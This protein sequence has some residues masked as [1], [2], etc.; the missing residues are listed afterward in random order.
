MCVFA[1]ALLAQSWILPLGFQS[2]DFNLLSRPGTLFKGMAGEGDQGD[3]E[4]MLRFPVWA[5][6]TVV[7]QIAGR[8]LSPVGFHAIGWVLHGFTA[9]LLAA[10]VTR[11]GG[12]ERARFAGLVAGLG[13]G[14][15]TGASQAMS[16]ISAQADVFVTC[17]GVAALYAFL[18]A[19]EGRGGLRIVAS[20]ALLTA[21]FS[22]GPALV[23]I[24]LLV[25][26]L[27]VT[28]VK[29]G[30]RGTTRRA[31]W[32]W[33][34]T[35]VAIVTCARWLYLNQLVPSYPGRSTPSWAW[36]P[37]AWLQL[38]QAFVPLNRDPLVGDTLPSEWAPL[39][40]GSFAPRLNQILALVFAGP[41]LLAW[42]MSQTGG[43]NRGIVS[44]GVLLL[45]VT[46]ASFP[47]GSLAPPPHTPEHPATN[48][49][50]RTVYLG[51]AILWIALGGGAA[52]ALARRKWGWVV[53]AWAFVPLLV[54][55]PHVVAT[56]RLASEARAQERSAVLA[57]VRQ[58]R[59]DFRR[60]PDKSLAWVAVL[61]PPTTF[62]GVAQHG[63]I[64][65]S[66]FRPPFMER[67][68]MIAE[69][70][71]NF[72]ELERMLL[73]PIALPLDMIVLEARSSSSQT[74]TSEATFAPPD[75]TKSAQELCEE[76]LWVPRSPAAEGVSSRTIW[77][78][79]RRPN[80]EEISFAIEPP[81][82]AKLVAGAIAE[83][84]PGSYSARVTW[85]NANG[86]TFFVQTSARIEA[87][88]RWFLPAPRD[89]D[90]LLGPP[91]VGLTVQGELPVK[92]L[93]LRP[94]LPEFA[95]GPPAMVFARNRLPVVSVQQNADWP[96]LEWIRFELKAS[97]IDR[98]VVA[99]CD[100]PREQFRATSPGKFEVQ[101]TSWH[102]RGSLHP[103]LASEFGS[104]WNDFAER[105]LGS[106]STGGGRIRLRAL[107]YPPLAGN[108]TVLPVASSAY[109]GVS[110][111]K[112]G[113]SSK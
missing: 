12:L 65:P 60:H 98:E 21:L 26:F 87:G 40:V 101:L 74:S 39:L 56:E 85:W 82:A 2:D 61:A 43:R 49:N 24:P 66:A 99:Y 93:R 9:W 51:M 53:A 13:F 102:L 35:A 69:A 107:A 89:L 30:E 14:C 46:I 55:G 32:M 83:V 33:I 68:E 16:W 37:G 1:V 79:Y 88:Q 58:A 75:R 8:P 63:S 44:L 70:P 91:W 62:A 64:V 105:F 113:A 7:W 41:A 23:W 108:G 76:R 6:W 80:A 4:Y 36:L 17:F 29:A 103:E 59:E 78:A 52:T 42:L 15:A 77:D 90:C 72:N 104:D 25:L 31:E 22:K 95:I 10:L 5:A 48:V 73:G 109:V 3:A 20:L 110:W 96:R 94:K 97:S 86:E 27:E 18:A 38:G 112:M 47:A 19:R 28:P 57:A 54:L 81:L 71:M 84:Q 34:G 92:S 106:A 100:V 111:A 67:R 50:G 45:L 11:F